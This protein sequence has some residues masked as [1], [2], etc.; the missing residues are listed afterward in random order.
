M[1]KR[2]VGVKWYRLAICTDRPQV[3][4]FRAVFLFIPK[5]SKDNSPAFQGWDP[6]GLKHSESRRDDRTPRPAGRASLSS[7]QDSPLF[8]A[9]PP[10][11][12]RLGYCLSSLRD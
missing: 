5:G 6:D 3:E 7:L 1:C 2:N 12:E 8:A 10:S 9:L 4:A 11:L